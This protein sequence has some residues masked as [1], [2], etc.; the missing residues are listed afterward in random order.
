MQNA[1]LEH[2]ELIAQLLQEA[3]AEEKAK[4]NPWGRNNH[5][6]DKGKG[7]HISFEYQV[8]NTP[9]ASSGTR[10]SQQTRSTQC[11]QARPALSVRHNPIQMLMQ[12]A[13]PDFK[14]T[15]EALYVHIKLLWGMIP[16]GAMQT[17]PDKQL[18][19]EFYQRFSNVKE[20]QSVA[21]NSRGVKLINKA[22][23][24]TLRNAH[25]RKRKISKNIINMRDFHITYIHAMLAKLEICIWETYLEKAPDSLYN[26]ACQVVALMMFSQIACSGAYQYMRANL[27]YFGDLG[28]LCTAYDHFVHYILAKRY[29]KESQDQGWN[30]REV[31]RKVVQRE[32]QR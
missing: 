10:K 3:E 12:D 32:R 31:E 8:R 26:E 1:M 11:P 15:K 24:Q 13:P 4:E 2:D 21:Q 29:K 17:A 9:K 14:Y 23:V 20:V 6:T 22:Q 27:T 16:P 19:K 28:L 30:E 7:H 18:L 25:S 5:K